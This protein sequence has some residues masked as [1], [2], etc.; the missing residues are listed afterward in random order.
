MRITPGPEQI[1]QITSEAKFP[2]ED[3]TYFYV[4]MWFKQSTDGSW[5]K[6]TWEEVPESVQ[7]QVIKIRQAT[8]G[9]LNL[10]V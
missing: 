10:L 5:E 6:L 3:G 9:T 1:K 2:R 8:A 4:P 7:Q